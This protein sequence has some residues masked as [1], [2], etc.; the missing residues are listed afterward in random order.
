MLAAAL[1]Y[2]ER[3]WAVSQVHA[4]PELLALC[5]LGEEAG[6]DED[7]RHLQSCE[8][9]AAELRE[10]RQVVSLGRAVDD[11]ALLEPDPQV[12]ARVQQELGLSSAGS[13]VP[14][15]VATGQ[16]PE[17]A[18][19]PH[20]VGAGTPTG[21]TQDPFWAVIA[22]ATGSS[23]GVP[24]VVA[25]ATLEPVHAGSPDAPGA[26]VLTTDALGRRILQVALSAA[27]AEVGVRY[28]WLAR[29]DDPTQKQTLGVLDGPYGVW[30]IDRSI[31]LEQ[32]AILSISQQHAGDV[33]H[34]GVD[35][36]RG[37]LALV[38]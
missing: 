21:V 10:L 26:A 7:R 15:S 13:R 4:D 20:P 33:E 23:A 32:Y 9:C 8:L 17:P 18:A 2:G 34:S 36:V 1:S 30:T 25:R 35:L 24:E 27:P 38:G 6:T 11:T 14:L 12:W 3:C 19:V 22:A 29:R 31:D 28:A 5:A 37:E 16:A